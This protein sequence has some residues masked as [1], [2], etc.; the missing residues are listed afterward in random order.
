M[1]T[2]FPLRERVRLIQTSQI[3]S[4]FFKHGEKLC[5]QSFL[6]EVSLE[7][8]IPKMCRE[9]RHS[10]LLVTSEVK[11]I[12]PMLRPK[13]LER[14]RERPEESL[15]CSIVSS[16]KTRDS[17]SFMKRVE[18][19]ANCCIFVWEDNKSIPLMLSLDLI[20][21]ANLSTAKMNKKC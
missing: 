18:S 5:S 13:V 4:F 16:A 17:L 14:L 7:K 10:M 21:S 6:S 2:I 8:V 15:K 1:R 11:V 9:S 3:F 20:E 12:S 19:S